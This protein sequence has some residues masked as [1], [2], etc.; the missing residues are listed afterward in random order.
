MPISPNRSMSAQDCPA[1]VMAAAASPPVASAVHH[2]AGRICCRAERNAWSTSPKADEPLS[3][4]QRTVV[5]ELQALRILQMGPGIG[6]TLAERVFDGAHAQR[7]R[8]S[9]QHGDLPEG[10]PRAEDV[11]HSTRS[12]NSTSPVR[13][14]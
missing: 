11:D 3:G 10:L 7:W 9:R 2:T 12:N 6:K 8:Q 5:A 1:A 14:T 13:T 4:D